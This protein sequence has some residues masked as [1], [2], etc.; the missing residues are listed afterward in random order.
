MLKILNGVNLDR[1]ATEKNPEETLDEND[2]FRFL[3]SGL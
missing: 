1:T 2:F 3:S